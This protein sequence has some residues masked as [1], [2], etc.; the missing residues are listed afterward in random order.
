VQRKVL[1][2]N[3]FA[4]LDTLEQHLL[5]FGRRY[6]QIATPFEWK[7]TRADLDQLVHRVD[8]PTA[9]AA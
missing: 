8:Q 9:L 2:P 4:D 7:F 6:E 3:D 5:A 1:T